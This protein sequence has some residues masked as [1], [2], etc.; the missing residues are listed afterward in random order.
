M[1]ASL[2]KQTTEHVDRPFALIPVEIEDSHS[3]SRNTAEADTI[4]AVDVV[5]ALFNELLLMN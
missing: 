1:F 4:S 5:V 3:N 2:S